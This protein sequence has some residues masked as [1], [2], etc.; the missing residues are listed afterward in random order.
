M[1]IL[2]AFTCD[3]F[4]RMPRGGAGVSAGFERKAPDMGFR[5]YLPRNTWFSCTPESHV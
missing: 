2:H 4:C 5:D 1:P 3:S